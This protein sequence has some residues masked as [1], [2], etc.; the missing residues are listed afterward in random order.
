MKRT[1]TNPYDWA[2]VQ[3]ARACEESN[4][5]DPKRVE[6]T[7]DA[8][9]D[10]LGRLVDPLSYVTSRA[11]KVLSSI[12]LMGKRWLERSF[13]VWCASTLFVIA[14][15][16]IVF[17]FVRADRLL[18]GDVNLAGPF[19]FFILGQ[20]FFL[21]VSLVL[22][23]AVCIQF[24]KRR[25]L[26][27]S[28]PATFSEK[29][30]ANLTGMIGVGVLFC[31]QKGAPLFYTLFG[32]RGAERFGLRRAKKLNSVE[33]DL[34]KSG[35]VGSSKKGASL[36]WDTLFSRPRFLFFW[37]GL[38][39]HLFWTSCSLCVL[40]V[41]GMRMQGNQYDYC[42]RT[43]LEDEFAV[44]K[45]VDFLGA[46]VAWLGCEIPSETDV[47]RLFHDK[48]VG[49]GSVLPKEGGLRVDASHRAL[50]PKEAAKTR[51]RWSYFL[52]GAVFM[53]CVA[54]RFLLVCAY[55]FMFRRALRDYRPDLTEP[56]FVRIIAEAESYSTK[57]TSTFVDDPIESN[58]L[59]ET[60]ALTSSVEESSETDSSKEP[61][62]SEISDASTAPDAPVESLDSDAGEESSPVLQE[63]PLTDGSCE[64]VDADSC[65]NASELPSSEVVALAPSSSEPSS[66]IAENNAPSVEPN[67]VSV[68]PPKG[69][70]QGVA[71]LVAPVL[72]KPKGPT[73]TLVFGYDAF[74]SASQ[75]ESVVPLSPKPIIFGDVA[76]DFA[77]RKQLR[78]YLAAEG[79]RVALC[80]YITDVGLSPARHYLKFM[81]EVLTP[82]IPNARIYVVLTGGEKL[83][84]KYG[85]ETNAVSERLEDWTNALN[86]LSR[87]SSLTIIPVFFYDADLDLPE[88]RARLR[89]LLRRGGDPNEPI[90]RRRNFG[91]W[92]AS[93]RLVL[94][95]CRTIFSSASF[96]SDEEAERRRVA[97]VCADIFELYSEET[98][99]ATNSGVCAIRKYIGDSSVLEKTWIAAT[100]ASSALAS[101]VARE[102][103][104]VKE[105]L[106]E[107]CKEK[108]LDSTFLEQKLT[109]AWGLSEKMRGFCSRLSP[110]CAIATASIGLSVPAL[111]AFAPL[112]GGAATATAVAS[113][114]GA[115]GSL[116]P[117]SVASGMAA[118]ALG[119]VAPMSFSA[120]KKKLVSSVSG[121]FRT[122]SR[123]CDSVDEPAS[124]SV[125]SALDSQTDP[126]YMLKV[127][128]AT[129]LVCVTTTWQTVLELQGRPED[130][131]TTLLPELLAPIE[132]S[133]LES[134]ESIERALTEVR[135]LLPLD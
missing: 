107:R 62:N 44:K 90:S 27:H 50:D 75:W 21:S 48:G 110:K 81:R 53:W 130:E 63:P 65:S 37:G 97:Q 61:P 101:S 18:G 25:I 24:F 38:L 56:Y 129:A 73:E 108:G 120:C 6:P 55:Y 103:L 115:L 124:D 35:T 76:V 67:A 49:G 135:A 104:A 100:N 112:L 12:G 93:T 99:Q 132:R 89:D 86:A 36:F 133:S 83:R 54:P 28:R 98:A 118:G 11:E 10:D 2:L 19:V 128:S 74:Y 85:R 26:E 8:E 131:I 111:V 20:I 15:G 84:L 80:V 3:W 33:V 47:A 16:A 119:A 31:L 82:S 95:E 72:A 34:V 41:L 105:T 79:E 5:V 114:F 1:K 113:T 40:I 96:S 58:I 46:P 77:L 122:A 52:L 7:L 121:L 87:A 13:T 42:W 64:G 4:L 45:G 102:G 60:S 14:L 117:T 127:E 106:V 92:D 70:L 59:V 125:S 116:L 69:A 134:L 91:K 94:S 66:E 78:D 57:T 9:T 22:L 17:P 29:V 30:L 32:R 109:S 23:V 43:S 71:A 88:P 51:S 123:P 68:E 126:D 39:S